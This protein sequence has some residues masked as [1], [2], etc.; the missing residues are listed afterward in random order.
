MSALAW[1]V[2]ATLLLLLVSAAAA[3]RR[4]R[5]N[6]ATRDLHDALDAGRTTLLP[7][8]VDLS[9]LSDLAGLPAPVQRYL[10]RVLRDGAPMVA[11][12]RV[13]HCGSMHLSET[14]RSWKPFTS[15]QEIVT[16]RPGFCW[17]AR[18]AMV[19][20][21][22]VLVRDAYVAGQG[23]L[24]AAL[25]GVA[26]VA[27][28]GGTR[29]MAEG[30]LMRFLAE[31]V[32]YPTA[33]LPGQG[34]SWSAIDAQHARA[35]LSDGAIRV[36]LEFSFGADGL[37]D[38]IR[39]DARARIVAGKSVPTPWSGHFWNYRLVGAM[40]VPFDAEV[41]WV[42]PDGLQPYWRGKVQSMVHTF[43]P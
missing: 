3:Y 21:V 11:A 33:L 8:H 22:P 16:A 6:A 14:A 5:W 27:R 10:R 30:E 25:F 23:T 24:R 9:D 29:D 42:M 19:P 12:V 43:A 20:G 36:S 37:V 1:L 15:E 38:G 34:V 26:T 13:H 39:A 18:I 31:A 7:A 4:L 2:L 35:T 41:G 32:W 17:S 28:F 40:L